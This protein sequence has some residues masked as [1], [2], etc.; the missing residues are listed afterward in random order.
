MSSAQLLCG[1]LWRRLISLLCACA[2][3]RYYVHTVEAA[4]A[5]KDANIKR[6]RNGVTILASTRAAVAQLRE[7]LTEKLKQ[8]DVQHVE[9]TELLEH[10]GEQQQVIEGQH[11][12]SQA[13]RENCDALVVRAQQIQVCN[14][15]EVTVFCTNA[16]HSV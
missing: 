7:N 2:M 12:I 11:K 15:F 5:Q 6:L 1:A 9:V 16:V 14:L 4:Y 8:V 3:C 13:E 10:L